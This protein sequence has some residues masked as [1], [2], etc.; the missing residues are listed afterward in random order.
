MA[1]RIL[2]IALIVF[3]VNS[4]NSMTA[5][6]DNFAITNIQPNVLNPMKSSFNVNYDLLIKSKYDITVAVPIDTFKVDIFL[7]GVKAADSQ[8]PAGVS[9]ISIG[10]PIKLNSSVVLGQVAPLANKIPELVMKDDWKVGIDGIIG[11]QGLN[12]PVSHSQS[13]P[14]PIKKGGSLIPGL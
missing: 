9:T 7:E 10:K 11:L 4:C 1:R 14:N 12:L 3:L 13:M 5:H 2:M 6:V 8:L